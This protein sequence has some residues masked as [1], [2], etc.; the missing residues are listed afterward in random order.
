MNNSSGGGMSLGM[1]L[2]IIFLILKLTHTINWSWIWV[3]APLWITT[4]LALICIITML[5]CGYI[6][7]KKSEKIYKE[8]KKMLGKNSNN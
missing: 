3:F 1:L 7:Y 8:F 4:G 2:T 6:K 5:I